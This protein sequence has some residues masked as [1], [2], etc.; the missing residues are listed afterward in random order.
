MLWRNAHTLI[1]DFQHQSRSSDEARRHVHPTPVSGKAS[2][3]FTR[4]LTTRC[5]VLGITPHRR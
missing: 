5:Q 4:R 2:R 1:R 3:A